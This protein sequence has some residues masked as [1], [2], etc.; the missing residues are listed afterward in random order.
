MFILIVVGVVDANFNVSEEDRPVGEFP[1]FLF[2][3]L[4]GVISRFLQG[5]KEATI[6]NSVG[7][8]NVG[9][10][11]FKMVYYTNGFYLGIGF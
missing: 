5:V 11:H 6:K 4:V 3:L 10:K 7:K 9:H 2:C 8:D 1:D